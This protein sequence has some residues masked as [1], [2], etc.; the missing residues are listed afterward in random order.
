MDGVI[1]LQATD[2]HQHVTSA[3]SGLS[4]MCIYC[5]AAKLGC[6]DLAILDVWQHKGHYK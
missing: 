3:G 4:V 1:I 6:Q 2:Y 5:Y